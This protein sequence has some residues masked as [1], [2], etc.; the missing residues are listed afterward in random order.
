MIDLRLMDITHIGP[1]P[2][3]VVIL[4][5]LYLDPWKQGVGDLEAGVEKVQPVLQVKNEKN[6]NVV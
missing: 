2:F 6:W 5:F 3:S 4:D 1:E